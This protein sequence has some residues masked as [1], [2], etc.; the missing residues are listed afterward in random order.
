M[1]DSLGI[2]AGKDGGKHGTGEVSRRQLG[3]LVEN[4]ATYNE[5]PSVIFPSTLCF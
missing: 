3:E 1:G 2:K 5:F 4:Y